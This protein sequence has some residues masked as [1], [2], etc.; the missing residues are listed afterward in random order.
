MIVVQHKG[1]ERLVAPE[2]VSSLVLAK[3]KESAED[4]LGRTVTNAVVTV[5]VYFKTHS[6]RPPSMRPGS[7]A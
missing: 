4:Y 5:P 3:M 7:L 1:V 2:E 6:V